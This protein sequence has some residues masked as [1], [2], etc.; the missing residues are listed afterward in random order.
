MTCSAVGPSRPATS[1]APRPPP[2]WTV[3]VGGLLSTGTDIPF[4]N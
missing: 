1:P 2:H 3:Q 4:P